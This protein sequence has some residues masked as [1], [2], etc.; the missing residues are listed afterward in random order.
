MGKGDYDH[1]LRMLDE[2]HIMTG[3]GMITISEFG[4]LYQ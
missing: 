2:N 3:F 4:D 1:M